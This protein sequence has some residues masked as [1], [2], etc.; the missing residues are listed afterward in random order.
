M[1]GKKEGA[2]GLDSIEKM[3]GMNSRAPLENTPLLVTTP[4]VDLIMNSSAD[5]M[6]MVMPGKN[7][8]TAFINRTPTRRSPALCPGSRV[9]PPTTTMF[10]SFFFLFVSLSLYSIASDTGVGE[11][12]VGGEGGR[13]F[14]F[15]CFSIAAHFALRILPSLFPPRTF[16]FST[17]Y[18][19]RSPPFPP[20]F[21]SFHDASGKFDSRFSCWIEWARLPTHHHQ[22]GA[23]RVDRPHDLIHFIY[24]ANRPGRTLHC[25]FP[26]G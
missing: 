25:S 10:F 3:A 14:F 26:A 21:F 16:L 8:V 2:K 18:L 5:D 4:I 6:P 20:L 17:T 11:V 1:K 19:C 9:Q 15:C 7:V 23:G 12:V 13:F 24:L 22:D